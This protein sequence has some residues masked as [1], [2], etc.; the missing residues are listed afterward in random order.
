MFSFLLQQ[1]P[2][3]LFTDDKIYTVLTV[4]MIIWIGIILYLF[5]LES[6]I[7]KIETK[8]EER[9]HVKK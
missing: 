5:K 6:K 3:F 7:K 9:D 4:V 1:T 8:L 2:K